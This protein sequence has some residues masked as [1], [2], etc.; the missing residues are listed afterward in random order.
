[1]ANSV[2]YK[3]LATPFE[4]ITSFHHQAFSYAENQ[5]LQFFVSSKKLR[6]ITEKLIIEVHRVQ[7]A[8]WQILSQTDRDGWNVCFDSLMVYLSL[9]RDFVLVLKVTSYFRDAEH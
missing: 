9:Y 4:Q 8:I 3:S 7:Q 6:K 5:N 2:F 1:M